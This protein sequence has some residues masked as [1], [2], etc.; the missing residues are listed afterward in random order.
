MH[1]ALSEAFS[2]HHSSLFSSQ[3][4][5]STPSQH[6]ETRNLNN[7]D[8]ISNST[9]V[10]SSTLKPAPTS[11]IPPQQSCEDAQDDPPPSST[12]RKPFILLRAWKKLGITPLV[13]MIMVKPAISAVIAMGIYQKHSVAVNYLNLGYLIIIISIITVPILP[14]GKYLMNLFLCLV[15]LN[16]HTNTAESSAIH[17]FSHRCGAYRVYKANLTNG[18]VIS[19]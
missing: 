10:D 9:K 17:S 16:F 18:I 2:E 4:I 1:I 11:E 19:S 13:F 6:P 5:M 3:T 8:A 12:P 14:R 7:A 15:S